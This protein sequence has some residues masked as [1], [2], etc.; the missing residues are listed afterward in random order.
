MRYIQGGSLAGVD[1]QKHAALLQWLGKKLEGP[2][3]NHVQTNW[4]Y[5]H[6]WQPIDELNLGMPVEEAV[7]RYAQITGPKQTLY[8]SVPFCA[9]AC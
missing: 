1:A 7:R 6:F 3:H 2:V 4:P 9:Q 5:H 8:V